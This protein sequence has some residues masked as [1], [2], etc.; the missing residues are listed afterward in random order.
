[1]QTITIAGRLGKDAQQNTTQA[2]DAVANFSVAVETRNGREKVTNWWR[3]SI[4]GK[5]AEALGQYLTK[6]T[7]VAISGEF[8]LSEYDGKP[9]LNCR[10]AELT[11]LGSGQSG[12]EQQQRREPDGSR[13]S[14]SNTRGANNSFATDYADD[15]SDEIPF[16]TSDG[17]W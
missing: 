8:S 6:G 17:I 9:Q 15:L 1:M 7:A 11:L 2:G 5:R 3:C 12:G 16:A 13:G 10:V 4:W 14:S